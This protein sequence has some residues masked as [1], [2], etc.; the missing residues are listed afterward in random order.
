MKDY[1]TKQY[2]LY[3]GLYVDLQRNT[4]SLV[5]NHIIMLA[6]SKHWSENHQS[7]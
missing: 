1:F 4:S 6:V 2:I 7:Y 5:T 3:G